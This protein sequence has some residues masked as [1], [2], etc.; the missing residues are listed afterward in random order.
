LIKDSS[1]ALL[2]VIENTTALARITLGEK[3]AMEALNISE[4]AEQVSD[5]S[6]A[7][8]LGQGKSLEINIQPGL[9]GELNP[10]IAEVFRNYL[11]NA[12][13]YAP[14]GEDVIVSLEDEGHEICFYVS[15]LGTTITGEDVES[16]FQRSV[17][18]E[19]GKMRGS[20]LG[21]AIVKRIAEVHNAKVGVKPN[22]PKGNIF[23]IK[24]PK[25]IP[26]VD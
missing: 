2:I 6:K 18:L 9:S 16:I 4:L 21:L 8:F 5:E 15:D 1:D 13:K 24:F 25:S 10:I 11:S 26:G 20:G 23:F 12:L 17:Q 7:S 3:I 14:K 19:N 22:S